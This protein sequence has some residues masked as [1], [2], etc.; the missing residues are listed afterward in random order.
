MNKRFYDILLSL[1]CLWSVSS[2]QAKE[3]YGYTENHPLTIVCD[4]DFR[5]FEFLDSDGQP[6]GYNVDVLDLILNRLDIPHRFVTQEWHEATMMFEHRDADLIHAMSYLYK[7]RPYVTTQKYI[8]YY[9]VRTVRHVDTPPLR[10]IADLRKQD[11]LLLKRADYASTYIQERYDS[12]FGIKY[13]S[14]KE[15]IMAVRSKRYDYFIWGEEPIKRK[16][17]EFHFDSLVLDK[18]DIPAGELRIIGYDKEIVDI[19]D[20]EYT[21][22]EQ[23]GELQAIYDKW[24]HPERVH[25]DASS[26]SIIILVGLAIVG[27]IAFLLSRL[28]V[29]RVKAAV[30]HSNDIHQMMDMAIN[31]GSFYVVELDLSNYML[32]NRYG[33]VLP[34]EPMPAQEFLNR[35][36]EG[37]AP[38]LHSLNERLKSGEL[39]HFDY[40]YRMNMGSPEKPRWYDV[41]GGAIIERVD[42]KPTHIVYSGRDITQDL[43][44]EE[45]NRKLGN[46]YMKIFETNLIAMSFYDSTGRLLD[47]NQKMRD[48]LHIDEKAEEYFRKMLLFDDPGYLGEYLPGT[49]ETLHICRPV[50]LPAFGIDT[51][52]ET[53]IRPIVDDSDRLVYYIATARDASAERDM[54]LEQREH[55]RKLHIVNNAIKRYEQQLGYLLEECLIFIWSYRP[56]ENLVTLMRTPGKAEYTETIEEY[57]Q[58]IQEGS[59]EQA[60]N[61]IN[62]AVRQ[63]KPYETLMLFDRTPLDSTPTWYAVTGI[64][65][66]G[67]DGQL[68]EY[69]GI[70]RDITT[71]IQAQQQL[72]QERS[73]AEDSGRMKAAF[74]ANMT[75][76]IRTPLN[77]IVG[78][79]S[80]LQVVEDE[81]ERHEFIRII[82]N[83]CDM[84]LRL[85][86]DILEASSM[87]QSLA[88]EPESVD[89]SSVFDDICQTLAQRV[90]EP[91]VEFLKDNPYPSCMAMLDKGRLQQLLTNF[92]TNA[93]KYTHE[94]HIKVG[95]RQQMRNEKG[96][97]S[98]EGSG[99]NGLYFYCEDTGTGIPKD[100][101]ESVFQRFVKLNDFVQGT[102]LGLSICKAIVEKCG[103]EIGVTGDVGIGSTFWFW[104]PLEMKD[105]EQ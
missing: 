66:F 59:R 95:Y 92:V 87:G 80:L 38:Q 77:A 15:G 93:V 22:L 82:R 21:R 14:P 81:K 10:S 32:Y 103:G 40:Q 55:D 84:L 65:I 75:H 25:D 3:F 97:M 48:L 57:I 85:I 24:F 54:Y 56:S 100:K 53:R 42:G 26:F 72:R 17:Q 73:R 2:V 7:R 11:T 89:V 96:E 104:I 30:R 62:E 27:F 101:Q 58:S 90:Q 88:I 74:L 18:I 36:V 52:I 16:I 68:V 105:L 91:G 78:F 35:M 31:M 86:N 20:D 41:L 51:F 45:H 12:A 49:R 8:N 64:P 102:G 61:V 6:S 71:L 13:S 94:G 19:I 98:N 46:R 1:L 67:D 60:M 70:A 47:F 39:D 44:E 33:H 79:S 29:A 99:Q 4:W 69:F 23:A 43:E 34:Y 76:E 28:T 83:N 50:H 9:N 37:Q 63:G 5:P